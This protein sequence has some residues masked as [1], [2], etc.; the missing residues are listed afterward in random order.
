MIRTTH[1]LRSI[2]CAAALL[3]PAIVASAETL[4]FKAEL[5][6]ASEVPAKDTAGTGT[7]TATLDTA[8][9]EFKYHVEY[10]GLTG[11]VVAAHFHGPAAA[12][13][14]ARP[15]VPVKI[16]PI[17]SPIDGTATLTL[18]QIKDLEDGKWYFNL[19][20]GANP[21]GEVRGQVQ[22]SEE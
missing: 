16:S 22:K 6:G 7:L 20:T 9:N 13:T 4:H 19:H 8:T 1:V 18:E 12:A 17:V 5:K 15:T 14:N 21:S 2:T 11:P 10:S 3:V